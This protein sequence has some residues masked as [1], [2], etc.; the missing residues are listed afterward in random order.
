MQMSRRG[1]RIDILLYCVA[2]GIIGAGVAGVI[3]TVTHPG[4][5]FP[6][7]SGGQHTSIIEQITTPFATTDRLHILVLGTDDMQKARGRTDAIIILFL[8][9]SRKRAAMLSLPRDL[10][11]EIPGHARDK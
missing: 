11:V 1:R 3:D 7:Q 5:M 10:L 6:G 4:I 2:A 8:N 9:P